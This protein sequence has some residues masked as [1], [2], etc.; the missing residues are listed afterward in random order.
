M[1]SEIGFHSG[2]QA[3]IC[4]HYLRS[5]RGG[6]A[7]CIYS[8]P[9]V[10]HTLRTVYILKSSGYLV[11]ENEYPLFAGNN[12]HRAHMPICL[13]VHFEIIWV[14][15]GEFDTGLLERTTNKAI[16]FI[17]RSTHIWYSF[18]LKHIYYMSYGFFFS[19]VVME[20]IMYMLLKWSWCLP[21]ER[22]SMLQN[23][24]KKVKSFSS[25]Q[26]C[27]INPKIG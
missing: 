12:R 19:T 13:P 2:R 25:G 1:S 26:T 7:S 22:T 6:F 5:G 16:Y 23:Q 21:Q 14:A 15:E 18:I 3:I 4:W 27:L 24:I 9:I 17:R 10:R 20:A 8:M 11:P